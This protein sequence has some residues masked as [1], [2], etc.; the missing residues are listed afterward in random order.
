MKEN[1][2]MIHPMN[3]FKEWALFFWPTC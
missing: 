3:E 2:K 1:D